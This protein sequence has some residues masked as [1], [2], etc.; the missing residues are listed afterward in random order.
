M[1]TMCL[2]LSEQP[3]V[4]APLNAAIVSEVNRVWQPLATD[5]SLQVQQVRAEDAPAKS[6]RH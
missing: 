2:T 3:P 1:L 4:D 6:H 5:V